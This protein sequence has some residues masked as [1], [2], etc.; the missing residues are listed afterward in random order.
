[1]PLYGRDSITAFVRRERQRH[2]VMRRPLPIVLLTGPHGSGGT[3]VLGELWDEFGAETTGVYMDLAKAQSV[4]D[5]VFAI[6][7]GLRR[8]IWGIRTPR[9]PRLELAF[10]AL[11]FEGKSGDRAAFNKHMRKRGR[12]NAIGP[13]LQTWVNRARPLLYSPEQQV[14]AA[15]AAQAVGVTASI[16]G[17]RHDKKLTAWYSANGIYDAVTGSDPLWELWRWRH[18][19]QADK[20]GVKANKT[21]CAALLA[22]L[23]AAF[24]EPIRTRQ[25]PSNAL[26]LLDNAECWAGKSLLNLIAECRGDNYNAGE[27][28]DP[29]LVVAVCHR[30]PPAKAGRPVSAHDH[31]AEPIGARWWYPV[32]LTDLGEDEVAGFTTSTW[33]GHPTEDLNPDASHIYDLTGGHP[34]AASRLAALLALPGW[35][36]DPRPFDARDLLKRKVPHEDEL[37]EDFKRPAWLSAAAGTT[38][39]ECLLRVAMG[40]IR[41]ESSLLDEMAVCAATPGLSFPAIKA[42]FGYLEWTEDNAKDARAAVVRRMWLD[43]PDGANP[44]L[45]PLVALLLR[46]RLARDQERWRGVHNAYLTYYASRNETLRY[47]HM[48]ALATPKTRDRLESVATHLSNKLDECEAAEWFRVLYTITSA[49]NGQRTPL[50]P[51]AFVNALAGGEESENR[52]RVLARLTA[53]LWLY[54]DRTFDPCHKLAKP[55][56]RGLEW[57]GSRR[58]RDDDE[59]FFREAHKFREIARKWGH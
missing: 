59:I 5:V 20:S 43:D 30:Q 1:M 36:F 7:L 48:L 17:Y 46:R 44:A 45:H 58:E 32:R 51:E 10:Y 55:I 26:L 2:G 8:K 28:G 38:V 50:E 34:A 4:E 53:A 21:L 18:V 25:R 16:V 33:L 35:P 37:P 49:P 22:D 52:N 13:A 47:Y 29:A 23:C 31:A 56:A 3:A 39:E 40:D 14:L 41:E 19:P 24:N 15:L 54:N 6:M 27:T 42:P 9:F 11:T 57:L 12:A